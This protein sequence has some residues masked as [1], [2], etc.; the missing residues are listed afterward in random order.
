VK[1]SGRQRRKNTEEGDR[2]GIDRGRGHR[3]EE[4][5]VVGGNRGNMGRD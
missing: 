1:S 5:R 3:E 4:F 2:K